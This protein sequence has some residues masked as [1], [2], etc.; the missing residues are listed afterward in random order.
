[1]RH[2]GIDRD[3]EIAP[4]EHRGRV[5]EIGE[6]G[7]ELKHGRRRQHLGVA[8]AQVALQAHD[9]GDIG[10]PERAQQRE[11][12]RAVA[13]VGMRG[14]SRPHQADARAAE[15]LQAG[16]PARDALGIGRHIRDL[17]GHG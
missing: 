17:G 6:L 14:I 11:R 2:R 1:M 9:A 3:Q 16:T 15:C 4:G 13:V 10:T 12:D 8:G 7:A 5:V